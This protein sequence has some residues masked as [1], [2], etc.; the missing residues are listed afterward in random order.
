M[1]LAKLPSSYVPRATDTPEHR[2]T[3]VEIH[4][5]VSDMTVVHNAIRFKGD[6]LRI[7]V[8]MFDL[9]TDKFASMLIDGVYMGHVWLKF[10]T[11]A[12]RTGI[13]EWNEGT[14][15]PVHFHPHAERMTVTCG[16]IEVL[17]YGR[18]RI[19][20]RN[21][22]VFIPAG[23]WNQVRAIKNTRIVITWTR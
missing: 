13:M 1:Q 21:E 10:E 5:I 22:S 23:T 16:E 14:T 7:D 4:R 15:M 9:P 12:E 3:M 18:K 8:F 20:R 19:Y 6:A 2:E 17:L 11:P